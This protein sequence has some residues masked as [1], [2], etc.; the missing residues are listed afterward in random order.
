MDGSEAPRRGRTLA[1]IE[2]DLLKAQEA[3][4]DADTCAKEAE[5]DRCDALDS[6]NRN[7]AE[8][9]KVVDGLRQ[10][11]VP[12]SKWDRGIGAGRSGPYPVN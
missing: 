6:I 11:S 9:D 10:R 1:A 8:F 7:Q 3:F 12:G 4:A 2:S 5:R